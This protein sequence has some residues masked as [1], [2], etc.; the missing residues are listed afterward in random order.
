M[1]TA[2]CAMPFVWRLVVL[3]IVGLAPSA[4]LAEPLPR[5]V[6]YLDENDPGL[7]FAR[8]I[9]AAFRS[10]V[11]A[12]SA[13]RIAVY[14]ENLDL[15]RSSGPRYEEIL[16]T[17][18]R[19]K[20]RDRPVGVIVT[21]GPAALTFMLRARPELWPD[22]PAIFASVDPE[23]AARAP[24]P[25]GA[26]GLVRRQTLRD[27]VDVARALMPNLKRIALVGDRLERQNFRRHFQEEIPRLAAEVE[28]IDLTGLPMAE[29]RKRVAT[30]P[31]DTVIYFTTLTFDG[32]RPAYVSRD[33][34]VSVA[35]VANRPI[36]VDLDSNVGHGSVGGLVA[37][38]AP[39][40]RDAARLALRIL[41]GETASNIPVVAGN[42]VGPVFDW[43]A[44]QR[45]NVS[46]DRL[47]PGSEIR[48]GQRGLWER[49]KWYIIAGVAL[50][51]I[52]AAFIVALLANRRRLRRAHAELLVSEQRMRL[53]ADAADLRFWVWEIPSD[54]LWATHVSRSMSDWPP[55]QGH[56]FENVFERMHPDDRESVRRALQ[57][58]LE[59]RGDDES[60]G[61][62]RAEW[63]LA[64][65]GFRPRW[66]VHRG[67]CEFDRD[68]K[69]LRL[70]GVSI[71][72][73]KRRQ[74]EEALR[75]PTAHEPRRRCRGT[76]F[77][78]VGDSIRSSVDDAKRQERAGLAG[79]AAKQ[80]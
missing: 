38:P 76:A 25:A 22:V 6:L 67:R 54:Q 12:G 20:Y 58:S 66:I 46:A 50:C 70:R 35:E 65:P 78:G 34:L 39:I 72:S 11:T 31:E 33:A 28:I 56:S 24:I 59:G 68:G 71:D 29:L 53:A 40:G 1:A 48:F 7:A 23:T 4:S 41:G 14:A 51:V 32:D 2:S 3:L 18:L 52:Q 30:L 63:R 16:K 64:W 42:F 79:S 9:S 26:T 57:R 45:W 21:I 74:T 60:R 69:P 55:A 17:Y 36:V 37:D 19:E 27:S 8:E 5:S 62:Y 80:L 44:L 49:Y 77:L 10:T 15:V 43:R 75:K 61:D 13:E 73:T 47:P